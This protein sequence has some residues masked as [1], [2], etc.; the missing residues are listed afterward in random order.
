MTNKIKTIG[1]AAATL[2][3]F[4]ALVITCKKGGDPSDIPDGTSSY[5]E[6]DYR[7][8]SLVDGVKTVTEWSEYKEKIATV[9]FDSNGE[10]TTLYSYINSS[11]LVVEYIVKEGFL[12][13][14]SQVT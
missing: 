2:T 9:S 12:A 4:A 10:P 14:I 7:R 8:N 11:D 3:F 6:N 5:W 1:L 13:M